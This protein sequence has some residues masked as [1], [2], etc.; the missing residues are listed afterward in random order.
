M[1]LLP[2]LVFSSFTTARAQTSATLQ[3]GVPIER[4]LGGGQVHEFTV[5]AKANTFVQLVIEQKGIDVVVNISTPDGKDLARCDTPN[6]ADGV[7]EVSF[8]AT[9]SGKYRISIS[10]LNK[11]DASGRYLIKL[12]EARE[13][14]EEEIEASKNREAAKAKGIAL[15]LELRE[16]ISQMR[17]PH[18]RI[19][20]QI[21][22]ASLLK[23]TDEKAA[24]KFLLDA[25][26]DLKQLLTA[27]SPDEDDVEEAMVEFS[28]LSQL[29]ND[30]IRALAE[31]D[32]EAALGFL[33]ST[34]PKYSPY[35]GAR[36]LV[37]QESALELSIADVIARKD[38][39]RALQIARQNLKKSY[40]ASL[41]NTASQLAAKNPEL[42]TEL[43]H[44]ITSKLL[45]EDKL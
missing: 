17:S 34:T 44:D 7:E 6:G 36:E 20:A 26:A 8:L 24:S 29:R 1:I 35:G 38:P 40:S 42:A 2:F 31:T 43:V 39:N 3:S 45:A 32:P 25:V 22:A 10:P 27:A 12:I 18:T 37:S 11:D 14:T 15:L 13:A 33:Q 41:I 4:A 5:N 9:E 30:V 28:S 16:P 19:N 21:T 23:E